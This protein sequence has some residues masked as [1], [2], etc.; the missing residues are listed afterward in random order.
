MN[1]P[2]LTVSD[3]MA[4]ADYEVGTV[5]PLLPITKVEQKKAP[6]GKGN[7]LVLH[8]EKAPKPFMI[9]SNQVIRELGAALGMKE[10]QNTWLGCKVSFKVVGNV[11]RPDGTRG[12]AFR[13]E[14]TE[15]KATK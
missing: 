13:I 3:Y 10:V 8:L 14:A 1:V 6:S 9:S 2:D 15:K 5:F 11:R 4:S 12:N 7:R